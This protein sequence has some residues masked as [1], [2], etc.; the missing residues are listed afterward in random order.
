MPDD[1]TAMPAATADQDAL[2]AAPPFL[3]WTALYLIVAAA[4]FGEI[5][6]FA[7]ITLSYR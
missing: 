7:A 1:A 4:L 2:H 3:S 6:V 5:V